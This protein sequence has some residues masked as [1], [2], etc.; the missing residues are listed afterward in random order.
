M[1]AS[2]QWYESRFL[3]SARIN[4]D[5]AVLAGFPDRTYTDL[6][7]W[8]QQHKYYLSQKAGFDVGFDFTK[9]DFVRKFRKAKFFDLLP[10][11]VQGIV[12]FIK[13]QGPP[14]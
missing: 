4:L 12:G 1:Y 13:A 2:L 7:I 14:A 11:L 10:N 6:Y 5:Q 9:E 3:P 8:I